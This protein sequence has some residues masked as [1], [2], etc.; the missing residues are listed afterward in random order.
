[1][2]KQEKE[3]ANYMEETRVDV[4]PTLW[5]KIKNM[6]LVRAISCIFKMKVVIDIPTLPEGK[7]E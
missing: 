3:Q 4:K 1:M 5:Q 6:K 7:G 2:K